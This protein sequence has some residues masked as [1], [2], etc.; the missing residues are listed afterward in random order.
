[1]ADLH[2]LNQLYGD[3]HPRGHIATKEAVLGIKAADLA[4]FHRTFFV[5]R[6]AMLAVAGN[7]EPGTLKR[8]LE[9][10]F[11]P[12]RPGNWNRRAE[13]PIPVRKGVQA[14][15]VDKP[16]LEQTRIVL[17]HA[18]IRHRDPDF[19]A[20]LLANYTLGGGAFSSRLMERIRSKGGKTYSIRSELEISEW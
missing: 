19:Y 15:L 3:H 9:R 2:F 16:D 13:P 17:G 8:S 4:R 5:A 18:G 10:A 20:A 12:W 14:L 11:T 1:L 7:V 6:N